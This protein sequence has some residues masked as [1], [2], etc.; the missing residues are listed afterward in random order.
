[1]VSIFQW[2]E[3]LSHIPVPQGQCIKLFLLCFRLL[4]FIILLIFTKVRN[5]RLCFCN[6]SV[7]QHQFII[8]FFL[9]LLR[10]ILAQIRDKRKS[11]CHC[12]VSKFQL[13]KLISISLF[14]AFLVIFRGP[15]FLIFFLILTKV[16]HL[17]QGLCDSSIS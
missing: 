7:P 6:C 11:F 16:F 5:K 13:I 14:I 17:R 2:R 12:P 15:I 10:G 1:M 8:L 3:S 9:F 4:F